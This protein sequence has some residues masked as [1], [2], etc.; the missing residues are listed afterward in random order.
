MLLNRLTINHIQCSNLVHFA[1]FVRILEQTENV[2]KVDVPIKI[3]ECRDTVVR[4]DIVADNGKTWIKVIA[5][6]PKALSD[7][8]FG[9]SNYGNKSIL[10]H[11]KCYAS[12]ANQNLYCFTK[13]KVRS[14]LHNVVFHSF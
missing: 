1:Y 4:V 7:T 6:N 3:H 12:S 13:P 8:A 11:A 2:Y 14:F 10:D 5:R 9:R